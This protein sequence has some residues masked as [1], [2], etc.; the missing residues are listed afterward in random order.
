M[1]SDFIS[2]AWPQGDRRRVNNPK[3]TVNSLSARPDQDI[4]RGKY[5]YSVGCD[6]HAFLM[7]KAWS[8]V[9]HEHAALH[10]IM[11]VNT[12]VCLCT[13]G[14]WLSIPKVKPDLYLWVES[15]QS[16]RHCEHLYLCAGVSVSLCKHSQ[17][18][19]GGY[20][21]LPSGPITVVCVATTCSYIFGEVHIRIQRRSIDQAL[22]I[23]HL[24]D[25]TQRHTHKKTNNKKTNMDPDSDRNTVSIQAKGRS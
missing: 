7:L 5:I 9:Q 2:V 4:S 12:N 15:T 10:E 22:Q 19:V 17:K 3:E 25:Q 14:T 24:T 18:C 21:V 6:T 8:A 16:L 23:Q 20:E 13:Y 1:A 11:L